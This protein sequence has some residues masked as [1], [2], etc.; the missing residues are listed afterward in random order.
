VSAGEA[1]PPRAP[2]FSR[3][4]APIIW[5][6]CATCHRPDSAAPFSLLTYDDVR[7]HSEDI[8]IVVEDRH[9]PPWL[10]EPGYGSFVGERRLSDQEVETILRWVGGG[11]VEG[12]PAALPETPTFTAGWQL[13]E[14]DLVVEMPKAFTLAPGDGDVFRTFVIPTPSG[15]RRYVNAVELHPGNRRV[16]HH[17]VLTVDESTSSR[18]FD[19]QDPDVGFYSSMAKR[20]RGRGGAWQRMPAAPSTTTTWRSC[21]TPTSPRRTCSKDVLTPR[22][23][24][25]GRCWRSIRMSRSCTSVSAE[26]SERKGG[27]QMPR[28]KS[29]SP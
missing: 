1:T 26:F 8:A 22:S 23:A 21:Y 28:S 24:A 17:A 9:M 2:T 16:V 6:Q 27:S 5:E 14:P 11:A 18:E 19:R 29:G 25:T 4:V 15:P 12:D 20:S 7:S 10:P 3:D 13:G